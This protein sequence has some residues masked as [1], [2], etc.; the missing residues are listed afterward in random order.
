[1]CQY[2]VHE[3]GEVVLDGSRL[4]ELRLERGKSTAEIG[5][6]VG[7]SEAMVRHVENG[8]RNPDIASLKRLADCY[9][10]TVDSLYKTS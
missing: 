3:R 2:I 8:L 6:L 1:M 9:G 7:L 5:D 4:R 10:V